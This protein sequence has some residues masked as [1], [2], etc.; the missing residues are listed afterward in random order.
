MVWAL[1]YIATIFGANLLITHVGV[2]PVGFG[3]MAPA[4]VYCA[5]LAFTFRDLTQ[6]T[7]GRL[8]TIGAIVIG[9]ALSAVLSPQLALASGTA[10]LLSELTDLAVY[11]PLRERHWL[12][13]V[14]VSNSVGLVVDSVL[15]LWLAFGSLAFLPGQIVGKLWMTALAVAVLWLWRRPPA[16]PRAA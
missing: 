2:V 6:D 12:A 9:A 11:T 7:L 1:A 16:R 5:G 4:G 15:F 3:L 10:F 14:A 13:A 8:W